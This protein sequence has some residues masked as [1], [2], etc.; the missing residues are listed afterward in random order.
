MAIAPSQT[1]GPFSDVPPLSPDTAAAIADE[2]VVE[3]QR[4]IESL[5]AEIRLLRRR[6]ETINFYMQRVDEEMRLAAKLQRDFLPKTFPEVGPLRFHSLF[7]PAGYVSGDL[8]DVVRLD[9]R[10]VAFYV[11]DAVGHGMPAA[12]LTMF[13]KRALVTKQILTGRYRLLQ[14][15]E[16]MHLLNQAL[17]DQHLEQA[18]FATALYGVINT[19]TLAMS[20]ARAGHPCPLL[21]RKDGGVEELQAEG[22]LLGIF[23]DEV[24]QDGRHQLTPGDRLILF[25]DGVEVAFSKGDAVDV[26]RWKGELLARRDMPTDELLVDL[27][28]HID[29]E[30][31]SLDAKD[32]LT[33]IIAEVQEH[34][35]EPQPE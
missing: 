29:N 21:L 12:L 28:N 19:D 14:P 23:E 34:P 8:Y 4:E 32:D 27:S 5:H 3:M 10:N 20:F 16:T 9:E 30:C 6:D 7:R 22:G 1:D 26:D 2:R 35:T 31:S 15:S 18:T 24:Y 11:A 17:I 13:M 25:T 33:I